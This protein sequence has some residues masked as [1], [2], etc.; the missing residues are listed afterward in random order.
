MEKNN[1][2]ISQ[3]ESFLDSLFRGTVSE[4]V[5][6]DDIPSAIPEEWTRFVVYDCASIMDND[7]IGNGFILVSLYARPLTDGTKNVAVMSEMETALNTQIATTNGGTYRLSRNAMW[8]DM[9]SRIK[10]HVN[11]VKVNITIV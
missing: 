4:N 8:P 1:I 9:D 7:A 6:P 11:I 5:F 10:W 2:N 3:I